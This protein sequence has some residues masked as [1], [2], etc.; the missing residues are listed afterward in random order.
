M[1][2]DAVTKLVAYLP[3][4]SPSSAALTVFEA[5]LLARQQGSAWRVR[6]DD[7]ARVSA[8]L[9]ELAIDHLALR[10]LNQL[11]GGQKQLVSI[12]QALVREP[13]LL[14]MDEPTSSLDLQ[15]QLE[16]LD[17][18]EA[19]AV[20]RGIA[21][22]VAL[23]DLNLAIR[24]AD[25]FLVMSQGRLYAAGDAGA[26]VTE[27][28]LADVYGVEARVSLEQDGRPRVTPLRSVR[29]RAGVS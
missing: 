27:Q 15:R 7:L 8:I 18:V 5:V 9:A 19:T 12:A 6:D 24:Y 13:R 28:M 22:I 14:L 20:E 16:V 2:H 4:E 21:A 26:V 11:S 17:V 29:R 23:H 25:H 10:Y 3:Q 1:R